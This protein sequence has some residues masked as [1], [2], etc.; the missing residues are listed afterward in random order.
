MVEVHSIIH[1]STK[2]LG[3]LTLEIQLS[4][5]SEEALILHHLGEPLHKTTI[6]QIN[7]PAGNF[8]YKLIAKGNKFTDVAIDNIIL[9]PGPCADPSKYG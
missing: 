1:D 7:M 8:S 2:T 9:Q 6:C 4:Q 5:H 3:G